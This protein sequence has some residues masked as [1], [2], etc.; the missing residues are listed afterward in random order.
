MLLLALFACADPPVEAPPSDEG[1]TL[2]E[3]TLGAIVA[4]DDPEGADHVA[5]LHDWLL[6]NQAEWAAEGFTG[7][8]TLGVVDEDD[9]GSV[10]HS[11]GTVWAEVLGAGVP[12]AVRG[13]LDGYAD[14]ATEEDQSFADPATYIE[15]TRT[16]TGG[17]AEAFVGGEPMQTDNVI[18]KGGPF[19]VVIPY[20]ANKDFRWFDGVLAARTWVPEEGWGDDGK[21]GII[22]GFTIEL[23][24]EAPAVDGGT[25]VVW[26]NGSWTQIATVIGDEFPEDV[27]ISQFIDGTIDY[28]LGTE[29]F[30]MGE[31]TPE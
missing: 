7:G 25:E 19:G 12:L 18:E 26:Y 17:S 23:W 15:W 24:F 2:D 31:F 3:M 28:M 8:Y 6:A 29:A 4:F 22:C 11:D 5:E 14:A 9:L 10:E 21:N 27:L 16:I 20:E 1:V 30:V 13:T